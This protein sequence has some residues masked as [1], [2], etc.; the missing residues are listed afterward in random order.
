VKAEA[1]IDQSLDEGVLPNA[2]DGLLFHELILNWNISDGIV[3][4]G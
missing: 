4:Q 3:R 1:V 2:Y